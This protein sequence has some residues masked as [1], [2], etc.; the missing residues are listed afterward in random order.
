MKENWE[1][2]DEYPWGAFDEKD[3]RCDV[4]GQEF[5]GS[6]PIGSSQC[7][8]RDELDDDEDDEDDDF[9]D[10]KDLDALVGD[11]KEAEELLDE[12]EDADFAFDSDDDRN[13]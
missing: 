5:A 12:A 11:D 3:D 2:D 4:C 9:S 1:T 7:P 10:I 8:Y 6:C 13:D